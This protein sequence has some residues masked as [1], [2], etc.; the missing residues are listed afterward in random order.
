MI[1]TEREHAPSLNYLRGLVK[2]DEGI[3]NVGPIDTF[4]I[5]WALNVLRLAGAITP[6]HP[7]V[8]RV[9]TTL[10]NAWSQEKGI[11]FSSFYSLSD[12]DDTATAFAVLR[13]AGYP[14]NSSVFE[15][16]EEEDHFLCFPAEADPSLG[17]HVRAL[18]AI[19]MA[20]EHP[21]Y[22][23]WIEKMLHLI[24]RYD[25]YGLFYF[26]KWHSSPYYMRSTAIYALHGVEN[27]LAK[28][29]VHWML[30]TQLDDGGWGYYGK[31]T[32]EET[33]YCLQALLYWE[34]YFPGS[35][36]PTRIEAAASYL[37]NHIGDEHFPTLWIGKCLYT[38]PKVV[39]ASVIAAL[40]SYVV[41]K[42]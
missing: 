41:W 11:G 10:W 23:A 14:A 33:A 17:A 31:S 40:H 30:R 8:K 29:C 15:R 7:E 21:K 42:P 20:P 38:P 26:D 32:A 19:R 5:A 22:E 9:T 12:L 36:T 6:D 3:P 27:P 1:R 28:E 25:L 2:P 16:F 18:M 13:W 34:R 4:E 35:C 39:Q 24:R 37:L